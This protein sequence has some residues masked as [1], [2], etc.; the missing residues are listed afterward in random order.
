MK[1]ND[2]TSQAIVALARS[3][4][5]LQQQAAQEYRPVVDDILRTRCRD[6][7]HIEHTLDRLLD[8]CGDDLVLGMYKRLCRHYWNLDPLADEDAEIE[9]V[10]TDGGGDGHSQPEFDRLSN[11]LKTFNEQFGT[12][13]ADNDRVAR[14]IREDIAPKVAADAAF[15]NARQNTQ[16]TAR[17]A[18]DQG[19]SRMMQALLKDDTLVYKQFVENEAFR[20]SLSDMVYAMTG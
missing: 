11:I 10:P 7:Q 19:L 6:T 3:I 14:R 8:F 9:P 5:E 20:R 13:F 17:I 1:I 4:G 18:H 16:H 2:A 12:L 15:Q